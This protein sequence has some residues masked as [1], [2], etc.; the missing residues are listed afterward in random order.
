MGIVAVHHD[1]KAQSP[2][3]VDDV[4]GTN[5]LA[6]SAD[7]IVVLRRDRNQPDGVLLVSGRDVTEAA[8]A[9]TFDAGAWSLHGNSSQVAAAAAAE[10]AARTGRG[11]LAGRIVAWLAANTAG[12]PTEFATKLKESASA[13]KQSLYRMFD[14]GVVDRD[15]GLLLR[16]RRHRGRRHDDRSHLGGPAMTEPM[17]SDQRRE[18]DRRF[19]EAV[20]RLYRKHDAELPP[21]LFDDEPAEVQQPDQMARYVELMGRPPLHADEDRVT[22]TQ[23]AVG[24]ADDRRPGPSPWRAMRRLRPAARGRATRPALDMLTH[25]S[26][27]SSAVRPGR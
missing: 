8:Y 6:G 19:V 21:A 14:A 9:V 16:L 1:R 25:L 23:R 26:R 27:L 3:F 12:T 22:L 17:S 10:V 4:S 20:A 7:T 2:D 24:E 15:R 18:H 13:V 11:E 5:G